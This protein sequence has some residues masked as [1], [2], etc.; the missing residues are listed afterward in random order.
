VTVLAGLSVLIVDDD[1]DSVELLAVAIEQAGGTARGAKDA[2][3]AIDVLGAWVPDVLL[4]DIAMPDVD[5]YELLA[6][7]RTTAGLR[8]IP[9]VAVTARAFDAGRERCIEAGFADHLTKP[10]DVPVLLAVVRSLGTKL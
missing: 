10:V 2:L 9:A 1:A 3:V 5:G 6:T 4:I 7:V 8:H